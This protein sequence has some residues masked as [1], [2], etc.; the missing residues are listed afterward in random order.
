MPA[1]RSG[2]GSFSRNPAQPPSWK[3]PHDRRTSSSAIHGPVARAMSGAVVCLVTGGAE[4]NPVTGGPAAC[5]AARPGR[6][7][8]VR[9][10]D[11]AI[12]SN[13]HGHQSRRPVYCCRDPPR[14]LL[15]R[16]DMNVAC[17]C[18]GAGC[19]AAAPTVPAGRICVAAFLPAPGGRRRC[20][21][22]SGSAS[23]RT[24]ATVVLCQCSAAS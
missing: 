2:R 20:A 15:S 4:E 9:R 13:Q 14:A 5:Y 16:H 8:S 22:V 23:R 7:V 12:S 21:A 1:R 17:T 24:P 11:S 10:F 6:W 19:A 3:C 18:Q